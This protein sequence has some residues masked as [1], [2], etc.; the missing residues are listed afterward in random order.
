MSESRKYE[1]AD[2]HCHLDFKSF[3]NDRQAVIDRAVESGLKHILNPA[4]NLESSRAAVKLAA[5]SKYVYAG[6]GVHP[7]DALSWRDDTITQLKL[8][9]EQAN[10]VAIGE[11]GLDYYRDYAPPELQRN[12]FVEQLTLAADLCLP[13]IIHNRQAT[14]DVL[15]I[16]SDWQSGLEQNDSPLR[17]RPGVLHSFSGDLRNASDAISKNFYIGFTGPVTFRKADELRYIASKIPLDR[18]L[19]ETDAPFLT[20]QPHRG[21]RNEPSYV[22]YV[23]EKIAETRG[24]SQAQ[25]AIRTSNNAKYLF[26]W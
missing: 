5:E 15:Q 12:I 6:V 21:K 7:N 11:I 17:E 4:I 23:A 18:M 26:N 2:T 20:P 24:I 9:V 16:L 19:I 3:D 22:S 10:V 25:V 13:V 1:L 14:N 8:L